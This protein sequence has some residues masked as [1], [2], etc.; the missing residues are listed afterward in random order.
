[1]VPDKTERVHRFHQ[2]TLEALK[3][4]VQ[5]AGLQHPNQITANHIVRRTSDGDVRLL[6][7]L[8]PTVAPGAL[9]AAERGEADW[10]HN[11][12]RTYWPLARSHSFQPASAPAPEALGPVA[13]R[14][15]PAA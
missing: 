15:V 7:R 5:A 9:L 10:P 8:L 14:S 12:F 3:E 13:R 11:V 6:V 2:N 1:V 4:L